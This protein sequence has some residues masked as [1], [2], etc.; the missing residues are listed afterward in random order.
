MFSMVVLYCRLW[1]CVHRDRAV[2]GMRQMAVTS[3]LRGRTILGAAALALVV[4][5]LSLAANA[6]GA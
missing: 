3:P 4:L 6:N 2:S 5:G 1:L